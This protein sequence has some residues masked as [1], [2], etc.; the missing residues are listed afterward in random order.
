LATAGEDMLEL[1][2]RMQAPLLEAHER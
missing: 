2:A 1:A